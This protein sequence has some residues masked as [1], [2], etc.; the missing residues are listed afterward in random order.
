[1]VNAD[2]NLFDN[3]STG[4]SIRIDKIM[5]SPE[6]STGR[7]SKYDTTTIALH[8]ERIQAQYNTIL[9]TFSNNSYISISSKSPQML[10]I[11]YR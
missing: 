3:M 8:I 10:P 9:W 7:Y 4:E 1:M 2:W 6:T 5:L 11:M